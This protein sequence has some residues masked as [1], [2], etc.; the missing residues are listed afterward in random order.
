MAFEWYF[1]LNKVERHRTDIC[2][3]MLTRATR[4]SAQDALNFL[5]DSVEKRF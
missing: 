1:R 2:I 3:R 5:F 4:M